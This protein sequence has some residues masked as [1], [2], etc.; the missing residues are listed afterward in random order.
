MK[1]EI[2]SVI[3]SEIMRLLE[4]TTQT[5]GLSSLLYGAIARNNIVEST[6]LLLV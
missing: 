1:F 5:G 3:M 2:E 6:T 4:I